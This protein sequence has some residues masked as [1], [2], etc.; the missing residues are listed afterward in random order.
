MTDKIAGTATEST[1]DGQDPHFLLQ[2]GGDSCGHHIRKNVAVVRRM[3][4]ST[5]PLRN[6]LSGITFDN[7]PRKGTCNAPMPKNLHSGN[8]LWATLTKT[9]PKSPKQNTSTIGWHTP[10]ILQKGWLPL[11]E[12]N[13]PV[14]NFARNRGNN[15]TSTRCAH[16]AKIRNDTVIALRRR[17][18]TTRSLTLYVA[19]RTRIQ[20]HH[21]A[22]VALVAISCANP[23]YACISFSEPPRADGETG[24]AHKYEI[25]PPK[26]SLSLQPTKFKMPVKTISINYGRM[27]HDTPFL[28]KREDYRSSKLWLRKLHNTYNYSK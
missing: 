26:S 3:P 12:W 11:L 13:N 2:L 21:T 8:F 10:L 9:N 16:T 15:N 17:R 28:R 22:E 20:T 23:S 4:P 27:L 6:E 1:Q 5:D 18:K 19:W 24:P 7:A 14:G 25:A